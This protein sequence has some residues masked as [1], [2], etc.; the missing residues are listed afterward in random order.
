MPVRHPKSRG[1]GLS[2]S[3]SVTIT[4]DWIFSG[5]LTIPEA[6]VTAHV[7]AIDHDVLL[8][9]EQ[10][11]HFTQA[12]ISIT[13]SQISDFTTGGGLQNIVEDLTPQLGG[14]LDGLSNSLLNM[15]SLQLNEGVGGS[16]VDGKGLFWVGTDGDNAPYYTDGAGVNSRIPRVKFAET[17]TSD[18]THEASL[19]MG[20]G[21]PINWLDLAGTEFTAVVL[22]A[23]GDPDFA[24][25]VLLLDCEGADAATSM[26]DA[27]NSGHT[28]G[29][30]ANAQLDDAQAN[31]GSTSLLLDGIDDLVNIADSADWDFDSGD[32]TIDIAV[33]F[34]SIPGGVNGETIIAHWN[35]DAGNRSWN[36]H[37]PR[38]ADIVGML[39]FSYSTDGA[40]GTVSNADYPWLPAANT[41]YQ[42][43][44]SRVGTLLYVFIDG[45]LQGTPFEV[46]TDAFFDATAELKIGQVDTGGVQEDELAGWVD[47]VRIT[48]GVGRST[49]SFGP[50]SVAWPT[51]VGTGFTL[52]HPTFPTHYKGDLHRFYGS[53]GADYVQFEHDDTDF[54][55]SGFQ[56]TDIN[57]TGITA[58]QAGTVDA[59]F[60]AITAT[61]YGGIVEANLLDKTATESISGAYTFTGL[62]ELARTAPSWTFFETDGPVDEKRWLESANVGKRTM[63]CVND[64]V[65][66]ANVFYSLNRTG[67]VPQNMT[68]SARLILDTDQSFVAASSNAYLYWDTVHGL[69][70]YGQG[71]TNDFIIAND[72]GSIAMQ[73]PTGGV[74]VDFPGA[75][76]A[77]SYGGITEAN[78]LDK[79]A[80]EAVSGAWTFSAT[81]LIFTG[82]RIHESA[83]GARLQTGPDGGGYSSV[84]AAHQHTDAGALS[85]RAYWAYDCY[86]DD[87]AHNWVANRTSLGTKWMADMGFH[88]DD[89]RIRRY[90][91][92]VTSPWADSAWTDLLTLD[93]AGDLTAVK[94]GGITSANLLDKTATETVSGAWT[95]SNADIHI[96]SGTAFNSPAAGFLSFDEA[97][98]VRIIVDHID[99]RFTIGDGYVLRI[100]DAGNTDFVDM[101]HNGTDFLTTLTNTSIWRINNTANNQAVR[102]MNGQIVY[103]YDSA[104]TDY[105]YLRD[106]TSQA[107][108]VTN[109]NAIFL[110]PKGVNT[111]IFDS[112]ESKTLMPIKM[113]ERAAAVADSAAYGQLWVK[114]T[115]PCQLWFTDDAGLDTQIV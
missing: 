69:T 67:F 31:T 87:T 30:E 66:D 25:V 115:T 46:G 49:A 33:Q 64:A 20:E 53:D 28:I 58:I 17:I 111:W 8:N 22:D 106:T 85:Y 51:N 99:S 105:M 56:T 68:L 11:E 90:G 16:T 107:Q 60:D 101:S 109:N 29:F 59:D 4:G 86:W 108:I 96:A 32:F 41:W 110:H 102:F 92:V 14:D 77:L 37:I 24:S 43:R 36:L 50:P 70:L 3:D 39:R 40:S 81:D 61:S 97:G 23:D 10:D 54:N 88:G 71:S 5:S 65:N 18:W 100:R 52:G 34:S 74:A 47:D 89:F 7:A 104:D 1:E 12:D 62:I 72:G 84:F 9:F 19:I 57:I 35:A 63:S 82:L 103:I 13:V 113:L 15:A 26:T 76:T 114:N 48:K 2:A 73:V 38:D 45:E 83:A 42:L 6:S 27:S 78:L 44:V 79:S 93:D 55:I 21:Q 98:D 80:T 75:V 94:F 91:G 112:I 95:F